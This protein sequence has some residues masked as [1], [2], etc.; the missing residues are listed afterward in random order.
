LDQSFD[1]VTAANL[2]IGMQTLIPTSWQNIT[3]QPV[4]ITVPP[5]GKITFQPNLL[6]NLPVCKVTFQS[7]GKFILPVG[8]ITF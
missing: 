1:T 6:A 8:K 3:F 2:P 5:V 7:F 4:G